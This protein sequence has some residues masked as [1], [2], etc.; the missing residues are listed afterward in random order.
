[1]VSESIL[2]LL[3]AY[4]L[5]AI[6]FGKIISRVAAHIDITSRGSGNIGATNVARTLGLRWGILTLLLDTSKGFFPVFLIP[7]LSSL[8][9][10][11]KDVM[12]CAVALA[13][14][15]GHRFS[16]FL[17]FRGGKGVA[18]ALGIYLGIA[19]LPAILSLVLF[20]LTVWLWDY[21]SL[22]SMVAAAAMV[23]LLVIFGRDFSY[24]VF[25]LLA[26]VIICLGHR[27]NIERLLR[28]E[29]NR[30]RAHRH[31]QPSSSSNLS[32]SSSE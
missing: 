13:A 25:S 4:L 27:E 17:R 12:T 24:V 23:P 30:W 7:Y 11:E 22:G 21:V 9:G 3:A 31:D 16:V 6:P 10:T 14:L 2:F 1:M 29:E 20:V 26:A 5:G 18:T 8:T 19:P 28:G 15:L 32:N